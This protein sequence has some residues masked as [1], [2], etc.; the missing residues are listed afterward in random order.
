MKTCISCDIKLGGSTAQFLQWHGRNSDDRE[1]IDAVKAALT[2]RAKTKPVK[3]ANRAACLTGLAAT[4]CSDVPRILDCV[5]A[6]INELK[7][8]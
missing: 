5:C 2:Y 8:Q 4:T 1:F 3:M 7:E 6:A